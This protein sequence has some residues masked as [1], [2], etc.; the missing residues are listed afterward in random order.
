MS[1]RSLISA[2][3]AILHW[4][5]VSSNHSLSNSE[6]SGATLDGGGGLD[7]WG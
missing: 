6:G 5:G 7:P 4:V 2:V 3:Y 1:L